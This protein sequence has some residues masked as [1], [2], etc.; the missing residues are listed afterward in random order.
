M[1]EQKGVDVRLRETLNSGT[2]SAL[3]SSNGLFL[4]RYAPIHAGW[5]GD[6]RLPAFQ[7]PWPGNMRG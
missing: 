5:Q 3:F 4:M 7:F 2:E 1:N 6:W